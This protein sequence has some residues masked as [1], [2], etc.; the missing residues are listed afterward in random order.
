MGGASHQ[1][2]PIS[3]LERKKQKRFNAAPPIRSHSFLIVRMA[4]ISHPFPSFPSI[5]I[6]PIHSH[7]LPS[8]PINS[9]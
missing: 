5:P 1:P 3:I 9:H 4:I 7:Q 2:L 6:I 8:I